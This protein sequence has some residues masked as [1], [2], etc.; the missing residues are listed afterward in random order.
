MSMGESY[1]LIII[2][3]GPGGYVAAL[4]AAQLGMTVAL[5]ERDALGGVCLNWGC[6]P[7]KALLHSAKVIRLAEEGSAHG[8]TL[9][10]L[11]KELGPAMKRSRKVVTR[12]NK[13][14]AHLLKQSKVEVIEGTGRLAGSRTVSIASGDGEERAFE[15]ASVL[16][17]T[18]SRPRPLD[19]LQIDG[20]TV[21][22]SKSLLTIKAAPK[23]IAIVGGGPEGVEFASILHAYGSQ[24]TV[25]EME[26]RLL[27]QEDKEVAEALQK[28]FT[29]RG[30]TVLT[31]A[32]VSDATVDGRQVKLEV[33]PSGEG[34]PETVDV[35]AVLV[36]V[37]RI[38]NVEK[39]G[40]EKAGVELDGGFIK[41]NDRMETSAEGVYAI[42]DVIGGP[43]LAHAASHE[44]IRAVESMAG[45]EES[46][47]VRYDNIPNCVFS[48]PEVASVGLTEE[49]ARERGLEVGVGTF[50][51]R[52][53]GKA[54]ALG[55]TDGLVKLVADSRYGEVLG[56][57]MVGPGV[58]EL[59]ATVVV[60]RQLEATAEEVARTVFA[61]PTLAETIME[62][63]LALVDRPIHT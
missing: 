11:G 8:L 5:I 45:L 6:I 10:N 63:A 47:P 53:S 32:K 17:A 36:S 33:E 34:E 12:L 60:A 25:V 62:A 22:D 54:L 38:P 2:G 43:M 3:S 58:T 24:V 61:H 30:I 21:F 15:A 28:S 16:I 31:G 29:K 56:A 1:D 9:D 41:V 26:N 42:G 4:R 27:P 52:A 23:S 13:G 44:G 57:H 59:I 49:A 46:R 37:G 39:L 40:L 50:P 20:E 51:L 14:V 7:T 18:G 19:L 48:D 55:A 35:E